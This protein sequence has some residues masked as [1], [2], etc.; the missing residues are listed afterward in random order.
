MCTH[1][2]THTHAHTHI[3]I[4]IYIFIFIYLFNSIM[5]YF[6]KWLSIIYIR[7]VTGGR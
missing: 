4:Y 1:T 7:N 5:K 3:Y 2:Y 6:D